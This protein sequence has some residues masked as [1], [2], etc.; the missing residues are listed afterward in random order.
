MTDATRD[1]WLD[2]Q[3]ALEYGIIDEIVKPKSKK[4]DKL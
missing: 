2:A 1:L 3:E 4:I